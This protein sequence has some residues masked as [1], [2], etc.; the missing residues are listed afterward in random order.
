MAKLTELAG[1]HRALEE[2][3]LQ[4]QEALLAGEL[5]RAKGLIEC[6]DKRLRLHTCLEEE[7]LLPQ[8][9]QLDK[10]K[11]QA[12]PIYEAEHRRF[13]RHLETIIGL[14]SAALE[15][16]PGTAGLLIEVFD[17]EATYKKLVEHHCIREEKNLFPDL[18]AHLPEERRKQLLVRFRDAWEAASA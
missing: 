1:I 6:Y 2:L 5:V 16:P 3:F 18:D 12:R 15:R 4:H 13:L 10:P 8:F 14:V 17:R 9:D 11:G 7:L